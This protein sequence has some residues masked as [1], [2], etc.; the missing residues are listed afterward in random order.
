VRRS[1]V[2][3]VAC[4]VGA[5][6]N[7]VKIAPLVRAMTD[8]ADFD[9]I[10]IHTGQ[11]YDHNMSGL[12]FE[13]LGIRPPDHNL[14]VGSDT[15]T[16]Q[17]ANVMIALEPL[18]QSLKP[19]LVL[20]VGDVNSTLAAALVAARLG[21]RLAHVEAGL[22]SLDRTMPEEIN[23]IL[24][25]ALSD[26]LFTTEPSAQENLLREGIDPGKIFFVGNVMIDSLLTNVAEAKRLQMASRLGLSPKTFAVVT[27]H[28]P[29]NVDEP[30]ALVRLVSSLVALHD[31]LPI[32]FPVHPRTRAR[33]VTSGLM[34]Q[35][36]A[37][38]RLKMMEPVG[39]L[40]FLSLI[41]DAR[42]VLTDSGGLQ[43][44]TT[45][46]GVPCLTLRE[47]TER[48][49]TITDGTNQLV[50]VDPGRIARAV[51]SVLSSA[52]SE[53]ATRRPALWDGNAAARIVEIL[54][55]APRT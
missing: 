48:P 46:I 54:R 43:E 39:Y 9:P 7:L 47:S 11:H 21:L 38:P 13:Q 34:T 31:R 24:T 4:I 55:A 36:E 30:T 12:F 3:K 45:I 1:F 23:R 25:D 6:P 53:Q 5:R 50:G 18:L 20:V 16:R 26:Y 15:T 19:D 33:L 51:D 27:L 22:R 32:V 40:E 10:V 8:A 42:I 49:V 52:A 17:T 37:C 41:T 2:V 35:L 14:A 28:R 44:E 29:S